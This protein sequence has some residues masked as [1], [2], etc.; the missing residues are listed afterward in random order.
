M[1]QESLWNN[2]DIL[3]AEEIADKCASAID[4]LAEVC[5]YKHDRYT[6]D[7]IYGIGGYVFS[8]QNTISDF[9][10]VYKQIC[11][12]NLLIEHEDTLTSD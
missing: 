7:D 2:E 12:E 11:S 5:R 8:L 10:E 4:A 3:S 6:T 9:R 1:E